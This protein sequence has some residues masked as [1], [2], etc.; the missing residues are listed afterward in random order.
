MSD[1]HVEYGWK[2]AEKH[3]SHDYLL[4][5]VVG[6]VKRVSGGRPL[7]VL[8]LGCGS[9]YISAELARLGHT[10]VGIDSSADGIELAREAYEA[11]LP[12]L[13]FHV[14]SV[15][16]SGLEALLDG[17]VDCVVSLE[18]VEH[19]YLPRPLFTQSHAALR[20]GGHLIVT[21]PYHGY[22]KNLAIS[23]VNGW[24]RHFAPDWDGGHVKFFS[25]RTLGRLAAE[26]GFTGMRFRGVGRFPG[27]WKSMMM[28]ATR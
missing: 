12:N 20:P 11:D 15:Y 7:R 10:V 8:D 6:E 27:L 4:P 22:F 13:R 23:L 16:D 17:P 14:F 24:D 25:P 3:S 28:T 19:L 9:G 2:H 21:T 26:A 1:T 5:A 18:V